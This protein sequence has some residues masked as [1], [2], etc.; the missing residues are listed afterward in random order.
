MNAI[1][2]PSHIRYVY[3]YE[4]LLRSE[5]IQCHTYK[6]KHIRLHTVPSFSPSLINCGCTPSVH[7]SLLSCENNSNISSKNEHKYY[8]KQ[9]FSLEKSMGIIPMKHYSS[10]TDLYIDF[11]LELYNIHIRNDVCLNIFSDH[12]KMCQL[13]FH[14]GYIKDNYLSFEKCHIDMA[15][16]DVFHYTFDANFKIEIT[17]E[18]LPDEPELNLLPLQQQASIYSGKSEIDWEFI[19]SYGDTNIPEIEEDVVE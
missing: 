19:H 1:T 7:I 12:E 5:G 15:S 11:S 4:A 17:F 3:Y 2:C 9:I 6:I 18:S 16:D 13:Y 10:E 8:P 14:T